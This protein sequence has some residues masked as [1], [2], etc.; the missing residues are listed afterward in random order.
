[1]TIKMPSREEMLQELPDPAIKVRAAETEQVVEL[2]IAFSD[3]MLEHVG[4][5]T[6]IFIQVVIAVFLRV[7]K[8]LYPKYMLQIRLSEDI[9]RYEH[10]VNIKIGNVVDPTSV[11]EFLNK[12][13]RQALQD[14]IYNKD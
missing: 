5:T 13:Y 7:A 8:L 4:L 14:A 12:Y 10:I 3:L 2:S 9:Y 6:D 11:A 1:M